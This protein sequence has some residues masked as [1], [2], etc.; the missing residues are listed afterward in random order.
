LIRQK[1]T[2]HTACIELKP[3]SI[4]KENVANMNSWKTGNTD[5]MGIVS[6]TAPQLENSKKYVRPESLSRI[7]G[8]SREG[9]FRSLPLSVAAVEEVLGIPAGFQK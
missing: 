9:G 7:I 8:L 1:L 2:E 6:S 5:W 4:F 3:S